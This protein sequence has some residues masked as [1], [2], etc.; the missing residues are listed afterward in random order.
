MTLWAVLLPTQFLTTGSLLVFISAFLTVLLVKKVS[1]FIHCFRFYQS[2]PGEKDYS[3]LYGNLHKAPKT[4][5]GIL[6]FNQEYM[7]TQS[8]KVQ[9]FWLGPYEALILL[10]DPKFIKDFIKTG[11][12]K[13]RGFGGGYEHSIPWF[14][15]SVLTSNG[16]RWYRDRQLINNA[17]HY[18]ILV[19]Y[20]SVF[21]W[22]ADTLMVSGIVKM[23]RQ[24]DSNND[25]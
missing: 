6:A 2:L 25:G 1:Y 9:R 16:S 7:N 24:I 19:K 12:P 10:L 22:A 15:E 23:S 5:E 17:F 21:N 3:I 20:V 11:A 4:Y 13:T 14:G 8:S 18:N